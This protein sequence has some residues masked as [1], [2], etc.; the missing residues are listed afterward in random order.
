MIPNMKK[1]K[2]VVPL[3]DPGGDQV[4]AVIPNSR[5]YTGFVFLITGF[6]VGKVFEIQGSFDGVNFFTLDS[7]AF[8][9][10]TPH[11]TASATPKMIQLELQAPMPGGLRIASVLLNVVA[12]GQV[13]VM[14]LT[15]PT[16][17]RN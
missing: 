5:D 2:V 13:D 10:G 4:I 3:A 11:F 8:W 14:M 1:E 9:L 6:D 12:A 7:D 17:W 15:A 16:N